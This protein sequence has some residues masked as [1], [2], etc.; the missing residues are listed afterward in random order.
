MKIIFNFINNVAAGIF[1][2][3]RALFTVM[4]I[5]FRKP[6]TLE[7]PEKKCTLNERFRGKLQLRRDEAGELTC[8]A[9]ETCIKA[10][11]GVG[12]LKLKR[13]KQENGRYKPVQFDID[14]GQ[15]IFCGN[16]AEVCPGNHIYMTQ[17][18]ELATDDKES[19]LIENF[20]K[21]E[22]S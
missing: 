15:C 10:C 5:G 13:E 1:E 6:V 7:Y 4:K 11:P 17:E 9:C 18:Y 22:V 20:N 19:L 3:W 21:T 8:I 14:L 12:I 16:C 2:I